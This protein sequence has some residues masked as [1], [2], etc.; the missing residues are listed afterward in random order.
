MTADT[1]Q[2]KMHLILVLIAVLI[3]LYFVYLVED[4]KQEWSDLTFRKMLFSA[5]P[6]LIFGLL[7]IISVDSK[8]HFLLTMPVAFYAGIFCTFCGYQIVRDMR[9]AE[10]LQPLPAP[11]PPPPAPEPPPPPP[12]EF[13]EIDPRLRLEHFLIL[14]GSGAGK[15]VLLSSLISQD[16]FQPRSVVVFDSQGDLLENILKVNVPRDRIVYIDPTD[17]DN[18][19]ALS[20]FDFN[21]GGHTNYEKQK[22]LNSVVDLLLFVLNSLDSSVTSKQELCLKMMIR[23]CL[24]IEGSTL[25]T[26][27]ELLT[28]KGFYKHQDSLKHLS[29]TA[30][31]F[32]ADEYLSRSFAETREQI[33]RRVYTILESPLEP[34]FASPKSRI[35]MRKLLDEGSII[36]INTSRGFLK[37]TQSAFF[38]RFMIAMI[39]QA[40]QERNPQKDN[41]EVFLYIDEAAPVISSQMDAILSVSRKYKMGVCLAFQSLGQIPT[42]LQHSIITNTA[43]KAV[44]RVSAKDAR[45]LAADMGTE[46]EVLMMT[47][48]LNFY[49]HSKGNFSGWFKLEPGALQRMP[50]RRDM[51]ELLKENRD[52]YA[53]LPEKKQDVKPPDEPSDD[54]SKFNRS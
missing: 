13:P 54:M 44:A 35:N 31:G 46:A 38:A 40:I 23:L 12:E 28:E 33:S 14:G 4:G 24:S 48:R 11:A 27:R 3:A 30:K 53:R 26:L 6:I 39:F 51:R 8:W 21:T 9:A 50:Q 7:F 32:F 43:I 37:D 45:T 1:E 49:I 25:Q 17:V 41:M 47:Q 36:L 10:E 15:T 34:M 29:D 52:K 22:N 5:I 16:L 19:I 20:F 2:I 18:P 42:D